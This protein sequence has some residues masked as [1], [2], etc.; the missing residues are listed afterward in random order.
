MPGLVRLSKLIEKMSLETP[1]TTP[2]PKQK[3]APKVK[4]APTKIKVTPKQISAN[5]PIAIFYMSL[6]KQNPN[7]KMAQEWCQKH[8]V[9]EPT[10]ISPTISHPQKVKITFKK[11]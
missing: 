7:S 5:D 1:Q 2:K 10:S 9:T 8:I 6:L 4:K 3:A 11:C